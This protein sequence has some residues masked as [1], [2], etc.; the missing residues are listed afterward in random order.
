MVCVKIL[1][2]SIFQKVFSVGHSHQRNSLSFLKRLN[3]YSLFELCVFIL[4]CYAAGEPFN[5]QWWIYLHVHKGE[6]VCKWTAEG[7]GVRDV[8]TSLRLQ[9]RISELM[10]GDSRQSDPITVG[11]SFTLQFEEFPL[12]PSSAHRRGFSSGYSRLTRGPLP[13]LHPLQHTA[14]W[15]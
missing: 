6:R 14:H 10:K 9:D 5:Q 2:S 11:V 12:R 3:W 8:V 13:V 4:C 7:L 1:Y 15:A